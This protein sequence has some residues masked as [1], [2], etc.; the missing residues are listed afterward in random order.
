[1]KRK[2]GIITSAYFALDGA[3]DGFRRMKAD[4]FDC[5]DYQNF[6]QTDTPLFCCSDEEFER[7]LVQD[8]AAADAAGIEIFQ[9]HA[10][11]RYP[12]QDATP[13][14]R[15]ERLEK[16]KKS[17]WGTSLLGSHYMAIHPIMPFGPFD[18]SDPE[19][20]IRLNLEFFAQLLPTAKQYD[21]TLCLEN[22]PMR[23]MCTS[24]P[25]QTQR[26][27][28]LLNSEKMGICLDTGHCSVFDISPANAIRYL[29]E[30]V[31]IL[32]IHDNNGASDWHWL[33]WNGAIDWQEFR[34]ALAESPSPAVV[35]L[36]TDLPAKMPQ[37]LKN[38]LRPGLAQ[39]AKYFV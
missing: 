27:V 20:L 17:I 13:E 9:T 33:P 7:H 5:A 4:G 35:S 3:Q 24:T 38:I 39:V 34:T 2:T 29:G 1:M 15:A 21:V 6:I 11:W 25:Y 36:E 26:I 18:G 37:E 12:P 16:M 31:K 28:Q 19:E 10:P 32:H 23:A 14:D 30:Q 22:M 8:K